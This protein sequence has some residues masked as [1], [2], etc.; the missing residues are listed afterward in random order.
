MDAIYARQS[1]EKLDSLSI[2]AQIDLCRKL[3]SGEVL[4]FEDRGFSGKNTNRPGFQSLMEGVQNGTIQRIFVYRLDRFSRSIAD[5]GRVWEVLEKHSVAFVSVTEQ[6]DT[7]SPMG[8]AMLN[9]IMTF[10]QLERETTAQRVKDNYHH[11][12]S[13]GAWPGGPAPYGFTLGKCAGPQGG[14]ASTLIVNEKAD[15]V[16]EIFTRYREPGLSLRALARELTERGIPGPRRV[17][18]DNV[19]LSRMLHSPLYVKASPEIYWWYM[20][21]GVQPQQEIEAFDGEHAC[22][23]IGRRDRAKGM[24]SSAEHQMLTVSNHL[25]FIAPELWLE[26]QQKL[27]KNPQIQRSNAGKYTWLTGLMKCARC[28]Y[29][30]KVNYRKAENRYALLCSGRS[31]FASC[32]ASIQIDLRELERAVQ[33]ELERVLAACPEE[34]VAAADSQVSKDIL[35][36]EE[37]IQRLVSAL[38]ES[39]AISASYISQEIERLHKERERLAAQAAQQNKKTERIDFSS[40]SFAE[41][42]VVVAEFIQRIELD[43]ENVNICWNF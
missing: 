29:S 27:E 15:I 22:N 32:D 34:P 31:N 33:Q 10:A 41:K 8:R 1:V 25:G 13:L 2:E 37:K 5:F 43:G 30:I 7:G 24:Y 20:S 21:K 28:G 4:V 23:V 35:A 17:A 14:Q 11:R 16:Q 40:L 36:V 19:T 3:S 38:A 39:S 42:K 18:W 12:F 6:F 9:I 26:V